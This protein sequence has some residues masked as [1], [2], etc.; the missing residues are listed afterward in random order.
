MSI[1]TFIET[2]FEHKKIV[3]KVMCHLSSYS[4]WTIVL[5]VSSKVFLGNMS[6]S[7]YFNWTHVFLMELNCYF[8]LLNSLVPMYCFPPTARLVK[9]LWKP[10][11]FSNIHIMTYKYLLCNIRITEKLEISLILWY[12][13]SRVLGS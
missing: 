13:T 6:N 7:T 8:Q 11:S 2:C 12:V 10:T 1:F 5:L 4:E 9:N 3:S